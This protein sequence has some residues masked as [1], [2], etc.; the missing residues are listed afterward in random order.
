MN[1]SRNNVSRKIGRS[2]RPGKAEPQK[3]IQLFAVPAS[4]A[5][6]DEGPDGG[7]QL[8]PRRPV[9]VPRVAGVV[10]FAKAQRRQRGGAAAAAPRRAADPA[11]HG[12]KEGR[13]RAAPPEEQLQAR[14]RVLE[15]VRAGIAFLLEPA[16]QGA[17]ERLVRRLGPEEPRGEATGLLVRIFL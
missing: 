14:E 2:Y 13:G 17:Q 4:P 6:D 9:D 11:A 16:R 1:L 5:E 8:L 3:G 10:Q 12:R 15:R 7:V